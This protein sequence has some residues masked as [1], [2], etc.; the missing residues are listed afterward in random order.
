MPRLK[1]LIDNEEFNVIKETF[2]GRRAWKEAMAVVVL[3]CMDAKMRKTLIKDKEVKARR[4]K[5]HTGRTNANAGVKAAGH[6]DTRP[7]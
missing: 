5:V 7:K 6:D 2:E 4:R 3:G 1:T